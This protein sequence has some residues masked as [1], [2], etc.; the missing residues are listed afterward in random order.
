MADQT[1]GRDGPKGFAG[2]PG[3][4]PGL[5]QAMPG[6]EAMLASLASWTAAMPAVAPGATMMSDAAVAEMLRQ[7]KALVDRDPLLKAVDSMWN[8]NP[9]KDVIPVDW[10]EVARSLRI[11]WMQSLAD[12]AAT[13]AS[14]T[15]LGANVWRAALD[16][17]GE[18]GKRWLGD[19]AAE[20]AKPAA[21]KRFAAPEWHA[22][23]VFRT[24][25][26]AYL[27]ASDW[28]LKQGHEAPGLDAAERQRIDF[29]LR[30]FVDAMSPTLMLASNP[31]ALKRAME[32]GG[33]SLANGARNLMEDLQAGRLSMVD[34]KAFA[35]G[36]NLALTPGKV[37]HRNK[38]VELIQ[39]S[40]Q[41][42]T[43]H[44]VP[45]L[46]LPPW[47]NKFYILDMQPK[48]S[49][50]GF[51]VKQGFTVFVVSWKNPD[52]SMEETTIED[53]MD[54]GVLEPSDVVREI[55]GSKTLNVMGYC[56]G[57]TLLAMVLAWLAAEGDERF[58][59]VTFMVSL[60]DFS[61]VGD[62]AVFLGEG[63]IDAIEAQMMQR[64][65]LDSR[66]MSNM[67]NLLRSNDLIWAN[68][69]NN[70]LLGEKPPAF[71]LLYW[72]SDGTRMCRAAHAWY[73]RNTYVENNLMVPGRVNLKGRALDLGR[74]RQDVYA[75]GA[76]KDHIVP[77]DA[78]WQ[79]SRL[80]GG[81]VRYILGSS[82]HIAGIINPPG[83]KGSY[84][85]NDTPGA[86]TAADWRRGATKHD[87]SWWQ[88]WS[89]WLAERAGKRVQP[90]S[91][92]SAAHPPLADAPG[93]YVLEK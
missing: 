23:P 2:M 80:A 56:I 72:N 28:L 32:T 62:T 63:A 15:Q 58:N 5:A 81:T 83:G 65:Y 39:Y 88:D 52:A 67:F 30:Q 57:G 38:L 47:I 78:A 42:E 9:L 60:Q 16:A 12:P 84:W 91:V 7:A 71:D 8:A 21:D 33:A 86:K 70:Y 41:T 44:A 79:I 3:M 77:W 89:S 4:P 46:V 11:V 34:E 45:I 66:E 51:L 93:T 18:A 59:A 73:L 13:L 85:I 27:L 29:H 75:V 50:I 87:G 10:G 14:A 25:K 6:A 1:G 76:E 61:R 82:G 22:N 54:L 69:V 19:G 43:V 68:V 35:P 90:P 92:G 55:T 36:R 20:A 64:G 31:V 17:W 37:V 53:Y 48:N 26:E 40:P 49:L 24:M 74:I